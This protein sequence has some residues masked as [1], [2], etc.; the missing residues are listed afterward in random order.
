MATIDDIAQRL[1]RLEEREMNDTMEKLKEIDAK[2]SRLKGDTLWRFIVQTILAP[3]TIVAVGLI[4]NWQIE[5][6]KAANDR[7]EAAREMIP[8][9]FD[10]SPSKAFATE[11]LLARIVDPEIADELHK[12]VSDHYNAEIETNLRNGDTATAAKVLA[13]AEK[14]GGEAGKNVVGTIGQDSAR[15]LM[16]RRFNGKA[17]DAAAMERE[18]FQHLLAGRYDDAIRAFASAEKIYPTYHSVYEIGRLLRERRSDLEN[19]TARKEILAR[20]EKTYMVPADLRPRFAATA[21][22]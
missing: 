2:I 19:P 18:G 1:A 15:F 4:V 3:L 20:I 21:R 10:N 12:I 16:L 14:S 22:E 6:N 5:R 17:A 9:L 7:I 11:R 8:L 13:A